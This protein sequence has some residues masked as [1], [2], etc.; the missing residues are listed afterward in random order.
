MQR[1]N[2]IPRYD[3]KKRVEE[4]GFGFHTLDDTYWDE[5]AYYQFKLSQIEEIEKA[6]AELFDR[7]LDAVQYVI[8]HK[9]Y[10]KFHINPAFI[11]MIEK[12]WNDD[13]PSIYGRFDFAY[14]GINPPKMLEF[15]ADT[16]TS[17]YEASV[18][19]WYWLQDVHKDADQF[20]SMHEKLVDYWKELKPYLNIGKIHFAC[21]QDSL[22]D[23]TTVEYLR[24]CAMQAGLDTE[25]VFIEDL[26][27]DNQKRF[28]VDMDENPVTNIF[29][30][31][32]WEWLTHEDFAQN[33]LQDSNNTIWIEPAWKMILSNKAILPIL[34]QLFPYHPNLL[35]AHFDASP[36]GND[37]VKKPILSREGAN[38]T[39]VKYGGVLEESSGD[40]GDEGFIYQEYFQLPQY[41]DNYPVIGSWIIG[42]E[43]AGIG[44]RETKTRIT[45]NL[46]R[47]LPHIIKD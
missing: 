14:D 17:L 34:W 2:A 8:D 19:Q 16:P 36:L 32:P 25:F 44:I 21:V 4:I 13:F 29:K 30:L 11:P 45:D 9:L 38:V 39:I 31:Y 28:F 5:S 23:L 42:C 24:D 7:C 10:D 20:N 41:L 35:A 12:S 46:S 1:F 3:W 37:Y 15:N 22:E 26:G 33:I 27:W 18:V 40:Y 43:P 6:T 47:F